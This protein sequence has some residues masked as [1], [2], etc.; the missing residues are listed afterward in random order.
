M[1]YTRVEI[2]GPADD[3]GRV[4][5]SRY[6][7]TDYKAGHP[8]GENKLREVGQNFFSPLPENVPTVGL[9][10]SYWRCNYSKRVQI[11]R[12]REN[13][14]PEVVETLPLIG[15]ELTEADV[16]A[17]EARLAELTV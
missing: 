6:W 15:D 1:K 10:I 3:Y 12:H 16:K 7:L 14:S 2:H 13:E 17:A 11:M 9:F 5:H 8:D 4:S